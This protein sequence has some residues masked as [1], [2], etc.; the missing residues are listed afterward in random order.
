MRILVVDD[1]EDSAALMAALLERQGWRADVSGT[2]EQARK[3]LSSG[4]YHVLVTDMYLPDGLGMSLLN[5][6]PAALCAAILVTG[7][8]DE[9]HRRE[10]KAAGFHRCF[11]K[12]VNVPELLGVIR[13]LEMPSAQ[14]AS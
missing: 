6:A 9:A 10:S 7:A 2:A 3:A 13:S 8:L 4:Q 12:P 1:D 11:A 14:G 5:P